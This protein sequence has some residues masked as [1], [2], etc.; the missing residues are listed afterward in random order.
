MNNF[1]YQKLKFHIDHD[2]FRKCYPQN[3]NP[4]SSQNP[5]HFLFKRPS[6]RHGIRKELYNILYKH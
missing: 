2:I 4:P 3:F 6:T 5:F 1:R